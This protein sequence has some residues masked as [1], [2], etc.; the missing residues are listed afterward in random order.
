MWKEGM[1][2]LIEL[3][4]NCR[5]QQYDIDMWYE[6][7]CYSLTREIDQYLKY[8]DSSKTVR[9]MYK[10][11]KPYWSQELADLWVLVSK[12]EK[13]YLEYKRSRYIKTN[14]RLSFVTARDNF[15]RQLRKTE[16]AYNNKVVI[17]VENSCNSNNPRKFWSF[18]SKLG[19]RRNVQ[20]PMKVYGHDNIL[21]THLKLYWINGY[22]SLTPYIISQKILKVM[23]I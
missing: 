12:A 13:A 11:H 10:N 16:T 6:T 19:A 15:D 5:K 18:I 2:Q 3:F 21:T 17:D 20:I 9:K 1:T 23:I 22:P 14:L 8:S 4:F 7:F